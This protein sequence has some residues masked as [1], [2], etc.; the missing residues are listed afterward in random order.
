VGV[1]SHAVTAYITVVVL[2][3]AGLAVLGWRMHPLNRDDVVAL[4]VLCGM[5]ILGESVRGSGS[6]VGP[7]TGL[8][9]TSIVSL[10][11]VALL[12]PFGAAIVGAVPNLLGVN[13]DRAQV[14]VFNSGMTSAIGAV[15]GFVYLLAGGAKYVTD[16]HGASRLFVHVGAPLMLADVV[17][18]LV[19][20]MILSGIVRLTQGTPIRRFVLGMLGSSG[21]TYI[22][23]GVIGYLFVILWVPAGVGPASAVLILAPLF[24]ARWAF[25]QYGDELRAHERTLS[26]LVAAVETKDLYTRGHSERVALLC[27]LIGGSFTLS[28]Q[29]IQALRFA[30]MLHDIG[31]L[32]IPTRV[33]RRAEG[34]SGADLATIASHAERGVDMIRDI[35]F[36][37]GSFEAILH[38]HE[39]MDGRG[40]PGGLVGD[41]IPLFARIIAVA[42]AF[43]SLTTSRSHRDANTVEEAIAELYQRT[44]TQFDQPIVAALERG[45]TKLIWTPTQL[46]PPLMATTGRAFDHD[47][48]ATSELTAGLTSP[49]PASPPS[50]SMAPA[51]ANK[52]AAGGDVL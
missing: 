3:A 49:E 19:N 2:T 43:D 47:D 32:A 22:G 41:D 35:E 15:G 1:P 4:L 33:L 18:C 9:F 10:S 48:P 12:G 52:N 30:G 24:A 26:A 14:R 40:Y 7:R 46:D 50:Y 17:I 51:Y 16:V 27:D 44:G 31:K 23:Y 34:V 25:V 21:P 13:K 38:H 6:A 5:G 45:L 39:R 37:K 8:T 11:S 42:D 28:Q 36:L 29:D 20:A